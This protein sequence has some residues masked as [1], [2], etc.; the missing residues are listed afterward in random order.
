LACSNGVS[1]IAVIKTAPY[2]AERKLLGYTRFLENE[3]VVKVQIIYQ[4]FTVFFPWRNN[5]YWAR[6]SSLSRLQNDIQVHTPRSVGLLW[7]SDQP[8]EETST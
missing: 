7:M 8:D 6:V 5:P 1:L 3:T 4:Y 2:I